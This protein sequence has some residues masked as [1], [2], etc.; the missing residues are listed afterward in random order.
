V[1]LFGLVIAAAAA[2]FG[3]SVYP[4]ADMTTTLTRAGLVKLVTMG[5]TLLMGLL[6][7]CFVLR[8]AKKDDRMDRS[9]VVAQRARK[10]ARKIAKKN[11]KPPPP[12]PKGENNSL[13]RKLMRQLPG[14]GHFNW[15]NKLKGEN[16]IAMMN[17]PAR[18]YL[19]KKDELLVPVKDIKEAASGTLE[20]VKIPKPRGSHAL[21]GSV[22]PETNPTRINFLDP[23][24]GFGGRRP[25][26][27]PSR[28]SKTAPAPPPR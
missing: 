21:P 2:F 12:P 28:S 4:N 13:K 8:F 1:L 17:K 16:E 7:Y 14:A 20:K 22:D 27:P 9:K 24:N 15:H 19:R 5:F 3:N 6:G 26:P 23:V 18:R 10:K 25:P 11:G